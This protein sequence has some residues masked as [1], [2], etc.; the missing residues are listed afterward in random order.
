MYLN[1]QV[2]SG[3]YTVCGRERGNTNFNLWVTPFLRRERFF[4]RLCLRNT[5]TFKDIMDKKQLFSALAQAF[6]GQGNGQANQGGQ[7][8]G[9]EPSGIIT[10]SLGEQDRVE[11]RYWENGVKDTG[12]TSIGYTKPRISETSKGIREF[13][14][15]RL[16]QA[17]ADI[18]ATYRVCE[19]ALERDRNQQ[20]TLT[21]DDRNAANRVVSAFSGCF[22][23]QAGDEHSQLA[24]GQI[25]VSSLI[26][27]IV[28]R[29]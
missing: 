12:L 1:V 4:F 25:D 17:F 26:Q 28:D 29:A 7:N 15:F 13:K 2:F 9:K 22:N 6:A 24:N 18:E 21:E 27:A 3:T 14:S 16:T 19:R 11:A 5:E 20:I 23:S 10:L 8:K